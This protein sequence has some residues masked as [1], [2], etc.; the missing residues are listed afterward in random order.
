MEGGC[1]TPSSAL[2][3]FSSQSVATILNVRDGRQPQRL[4]GCLMWGAGITVVRA[5]DHV[6]YA[7]KRDGG[8]GKTGRGCIPRMQASPVSGADGGADETLERRLRRAGWGWMYQCIHSTTPLASAMMFLA[9]FA[10]T[11]RLKIQETVP[12]PR[13]AAPISTP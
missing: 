12:F 10:S 1:E 7:W 2:S 4:F 13:P 3:L 11:A 8:A 9:G 6:R 5:A